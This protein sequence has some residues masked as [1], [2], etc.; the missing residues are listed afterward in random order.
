[1]SYDEKDLTL[2]D[3]KNLRDNKLYCYFVKKFSVLQF[4]C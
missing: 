3:K 4:T 2:F 1:M